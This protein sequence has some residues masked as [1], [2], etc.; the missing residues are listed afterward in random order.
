MYHFKPLNPDDVTARALIL[1]VL[2]T[3]GTDQQSIAELIHTGDV[4]GIDAKAM[5]VAATRLVKEGLLDSPQRGVYQRGQKAEGITR[6]VR[7]WQNVSDAIG[8]WDGNWIINF[9]Q[10]LGRTDR[11]KLRSAE[12]AYGLLG[13]Q[14]AEP[15]MWVRPDNLTEDLAGHRGRLIELGA[16]ADTLTIAT[17][18][19]ALPPETDWRELWSVNDLQ[20]SYQAAIEEMDKSLARLDQLSAP[21]AARE[22]LLVGQAV[23]RAINLDPLLPKEFGVLET[24]LSMVEKMK[25]YNTAGR[26]AWK[27]YRSLRAN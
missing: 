26:A 17:K 16:D 22:T 12:R 2:N 19:T 21:E 1:S 3:I 23:I 18:A 6:H 15:G 14:Q 13:Y 9:S 24:L 4:F 27:N 11:K 10:H 20:H 8:D 5:R 7:K 25:V